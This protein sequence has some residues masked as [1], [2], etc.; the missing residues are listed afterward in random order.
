LIAAGCGSSA[1]DR[2]CAADGAQKQR[3]NC[4][5]WV[6]MQKILRAALKHRRFAPAIVA[7]MLMP[8]SGCILVGPD[9]VRPKVITP[10]AYKEIDG[11]ESR[12]AEG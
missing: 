11:L 8:L 3:R 1:A 9:Y 6:A 2:T 12:P 10:D 5:Q 7:A 4:D